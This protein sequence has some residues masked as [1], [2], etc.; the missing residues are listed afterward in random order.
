MPS[1]R[2]ITADALIGRSSSEHLVNLSFEL[3]TRQ[4]AVPGDGGGIGKAISAASARRPAGARATG[5]GGGA[6][7][8]APR[9]NRRWSRSGKS[10][11]VNLAV[12]S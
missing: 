10:Q 12:G 8:G 3:P 7:G 4:G 11:V 1:T 9:S 2:L 6:R 5:A